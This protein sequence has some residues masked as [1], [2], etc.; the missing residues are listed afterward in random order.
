[1][2]FNS[3]FNFDIFLT[4]NIFGFNNYT[5][6]PPT[7][8]NIDQKLFLFQRFFPGALAV[9]IMALLLWISILGNNK[10]TRKIVIAGNNDKIF[11][12]II[13]GLLIFA[14]IFTT[15]ENSATLGTFFAAYGYFD[16]DT[17]IQKFILT[18]PKRLQ[19]LEEY[20]ISCDDLQNCEYGPFG[21][22]ATSEDSYYLILWKKEDHKPLT[23]NPGLYIIP[24]N[25]SKGA[26]LLFPE[27][28]EILEQPTSEEENKIDN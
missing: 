26:F 19:Y 28:S 8:A 16:A 23:R 15:F 18:C 20:E 14:I 4:K 5:I 7:P 6:I 2:V 24:R 10:F 25:D 13:W 9:I 22:I 27:N 21:L 1:M 11:R 3:L 12:N 17:K